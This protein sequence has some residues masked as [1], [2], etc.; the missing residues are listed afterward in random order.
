MALFG[1]SNYNNAPATVTSVEP[2]RGEVHQELLRWQQQIGNNEDGTPDYL[3]H[4]YLARF[5]VVGSI[6]TTVYTGLDKA[7]AIALANSLTKQD[8]YA[9]A[10]GGYGCQ[11]PYLSKSE[12]ASVRRVAGRMYEVTLVVEERTCSDINL[13]S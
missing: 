11:F 12:R 13:K 3:N 7:G 5:F 9:V 2:I 8:A 4:S 6:T 10:V 1:T